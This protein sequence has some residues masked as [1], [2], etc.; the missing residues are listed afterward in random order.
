MNNAGKNLNQRRFSCAI[1][2]TDRMNLGGSEI[3]IDIAQSTHAVVGFAQIADLNQSLGVGH[4]ADPDP[5]TAAEDLA[6]QE[7]RRLSTFFS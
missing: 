5:A 2:T 6:E 7:S 4:R 1:F 3:Q